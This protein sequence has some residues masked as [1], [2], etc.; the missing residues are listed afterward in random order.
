MDPTKLEHIGKIELY[1]L[2]NEELEN[3]Y[4][5]TEIENRTYFENFMLPEAI[6]RMM[7]TN[8]Y[9][10]ILNKEY[11]EMID[12]RDQLRNVFF[13]HVEVI[14]DIHTHMPINLYRVISSQLIKFNI[15]HYDLSDMTPNYIVSEYNKIMEEIVQYLP[16]KQQNWKLFKIIFKSFISCK[17]I[18]SEYRMS[19]IAFD[20][21]ILLIKEKMISALIT[22]GEMVGIIGA[23]T[24]GEISTQLT[25]NSVTYETNII[26]R[27]ENKNIKKIQIGDFVTKNINES[28]KQNYNK[29]KDTTYAECLNYY[30]IPSCDI[31]G[32]TVWNRIEAVT[33]HPVINEDGTNTM[34]KIKTYNNREV[35]ATKAKSFLQLING[36][37][38]ESAGSNL[39]VGDYLPVSIKNIEYKKIYNLD[40]KTILSPYEY[41]FGTELEK[42]KNVMNEHHWWKKYNNVLFKLPYK[43]S[44]TV[45]AL[46]HGNK[47]KTSDKKLIYKE[48]YIY[49]LKNNID[50]Y[51]IPENINLDYNFGYLLGAYAAEGCMTN[52]QIS[53]SNN[54]LNYLRP[55]EEICI[56]FNLT[57]KIYKQNNKNKENWTSQ[58]IR[59]YNTVLCRIF[60]KLIGKLSSNKYIHESIIFSNDECLKGFLDA[61][62]CGDGTIHRRKKNNGSYKYENLSI[63]STSLNLLTDVSII[64]KNMDIISN[65][66]KFKKPEKNNRN[67]QNIQQAYTLYVTNQQCVKISKILNLSNK[68]KQK[69]LI[70][71]GIKNFK[72][73][74]SQK[75]E[76]IPNIVN[77]Q[78]IYEERNNR[79]KDIIFDK[80]ISIE[81]ISNTTDYA[82]D[83]TVENTRN[84]DIYN[85]LC[86]RD[87]F[88][89]AGVGAASVVITEGVPRLKEILRLS[90]NLKTKNMNIFLKDEYS[91]D[92]EEARKV[93]TKFA[94]TQIKDVLESSEILYAG[95]TGNTSNQEDLEFIQSY[96]EFSELFG[97]DN[98]SE[99]IESPWILRLK[100]D[101]ESLMN[102]KI[103]IQEIQEAIKEKSMND[104]EC[105]YSDDSAQDVVMRIRI[106]Q[107]STEDFLN[108][109]KEFEK[110]LSE[111]SLRGI[112]NIN[113]AE[114]F[115]GNI[116]KYNLDGS[117]KASKEWKISTEGS[118]LNEILTNN[119]VDF[120]RTYTNDILEFYEIF[121]IE[122]TRELIFREL[123]KVLPGGKKPNIRHIQ[124]LSDI[125][126]Y[127]GILMQIE[128][129]GLN[130]NPEVGPLSKASFEEVMN[131]LTNAAV[132]GEKDNMKGGS[133][134][135]FAG[136]FCK[137]GTNSF[138]ILVDEEKLMEKM[139]NGEYVLENINVKPENIDNMMNELYNKKEENTNIKETDFNFGFGMESK[140]EFMLGS[141]GEFKLSIGRSY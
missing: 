24:L 43:R 37:I 110:Q 91:Y 117:I 119:S 101:K 4:K 15:N 123:S 107:E 6:D 96:K 81:E 64:L 20:D 55:I 40:L 115:E 137:N 41:I 125:M 73:E 104:I 80:I 140:K 44:D 126:T 48:G 16:E 25:L 113:R 106:K 52:N 134:N 95:K 61:Y 11:E 32:N 19:K 47:R 3:K 76:R 108:Y 21:L 83:L 38:Q 103:T 68:E 141:T 69:K 98:M 65:I 135:I 57:Y 82:Y 72:H 132:F 138:E 50:S 22:P 1:E 124:M 60:E 34:L 35:I 129:H 17:R 18:L 131:I 63:T 136:Q 128:R 88:H 14:G 62:I 59:I 31:N 26:V 42:A 51:C 54:D 116:I 89:N 28:N 118:N 85:G 30:E 112:S 45:Y 10:S 99:Q 8:E 23:Q 90:K 70:E 49:T 2:N 121:G 9:I 33:Q 71:L 133:A 84:F 87:T 105:I 111:F 86:M 93:Q 92:K 67:S 5:F 66:Y 122:A 29:E 53:I 36:K 46:I 127:R 12:Y 79:F 75:Y 56:R 13:K 7:E 114:L 27:D 102:K 58:D 109:M 39:K 97:I 77:N 139:D 94:F 100:F 78:V 74:I 120:T 130:K